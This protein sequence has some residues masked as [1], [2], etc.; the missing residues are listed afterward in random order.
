MGDSQEREFVSMLKK[1][2]GTLGIA[3]KFFQVRNVAFEVA[4]VHSQTLQ[5]GLFSVWLMQ[6]DFNMYGSP[7]NLRISWKFYE[8]TMH[9]WAVYNRSRDRDFSIDQQLFDHFN[10]RVSEVRE[11]SVK[12][13]LFVFHCDADES[14]FLMILWELQTSGR[15]VENVGYPDPE[16]Q[17][18]DVF[19]LNPANA[20][21]AKYMVWIHCVSLSLALSTIVWA[22]VE[23][24]IQPW[25]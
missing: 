9:D 17:R 19:V 21:T 6:A 24:S 10:I 15:A 23:L 8:G 20:H 11:H 14:E 5:S 4:N 16:L 3:T 7:N 2:N 22:T 12:N 1:A 18:P 13:P 25:L